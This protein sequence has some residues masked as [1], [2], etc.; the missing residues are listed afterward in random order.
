MNYLEKLNGSINHS[1]PLPDIV[2]AFEEMCEETID[3]D[4]ILF[5]TGTFTFHTINREPRFY[6]SLVRQFPIENDDEYYQIHVDILFLPDSIN[7]TFSGAVWNEDIEENIFD[8]IR[9]SKAFAYAES[10]AYEQIKI[11]MDET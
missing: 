5:E 9:N 3:N 6:F 2:K 1:M 10:A 7:R 11:Y 8:Y 4:M